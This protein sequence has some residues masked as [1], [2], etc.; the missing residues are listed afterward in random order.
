MRSV[1]LDSIVD[2]ARATILQAQAVAFDA[3]C[4]TTSLPGLRVET[5]SFDAPIAEAIGRNFVNAAGK[6]EACLRCIVVHGDQPGIE[7][8]ASWSRTEFYRP[9]E[10]AEAFAKHGL[11]GSYFYDS[12]HWHLMDCG[13]NLAVQLMRSPGAYPQWEI[14]APLRP[15][16]HWH[17]ALR[18]RRL[19]HC[20]TLGVDGSGVILAGG[21]GSGKSGT[22]IGGL[23]HGLQSVGDDYVLLDA[24]DH[25]VEAR[26]VFATLKQ[27]PAGVAR[28][29]M[30]A[31]FSDKPL[32]WQG[33]YEFV[34]G[35]VSPLPVPDR[36]EIKALLLP[37]VTGAA[38]T[39]LQPVGRSEA[40]IALA[41]SSIYQMPGERES[42]FRFFGRV[43]RTL[44]CYRLNLGCNAV[45]VADV[46][47][48]FIVRPT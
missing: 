16:L 9:Q 12:D 3:P 23:L 30:S 35:D 4:L 48:D 2:Y 1:G 29:G 6:A 8:P 19:G 28:L 22:V 41:A 31:M 36:L 39:T 5:V 13:S 32:N 14:G 47:R 38:R 15:F 40:M 45:E 18:N 37:C 34:I 20:G 25:R 17:Y 27:D 46:I 42:G 33:K 43:T 26:A 24:N 11:C 44:P 10:V 7:A 21:G